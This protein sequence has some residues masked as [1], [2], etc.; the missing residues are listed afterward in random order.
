MAGIVTKRLSTGAAT[1]RQALSEW[2]IATWWLVVLW[3]LAVLFSVVTT[4]W[5]SITAAILIGLAA[6]VLV[7]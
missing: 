3:P 4:R 6:L 2:D 5:Y 7:V 1:S